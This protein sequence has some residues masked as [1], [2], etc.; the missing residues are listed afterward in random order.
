MEQDH[1]AI[2]KWVNAKQS[3]RAFGAAWRTIEGYEAVHMLRKGQVRWV[4]GDDVHRQLLLMH[5]LF[6]LAA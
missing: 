4:A 5:T 3:F 6:G 2:K 1:R